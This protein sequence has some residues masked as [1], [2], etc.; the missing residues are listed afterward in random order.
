MS[1][2]IAIIVITR[3][4]DSDEPSGNLASTGDL[5]LHDGMGGYDELT[6]AE[7]AKAF[8]EKMIYSEVFQKSEILIVDAVTHR[9]LSGD[10][11]KP[12][13]WDVD[14]EVFDDLHQAVQRAEELREW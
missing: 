8:P 2:S 6:L 5:Y 13:K 3:V 10:G 9:E 7:Q 11:R 14:Y 1:P 12:S 4:P